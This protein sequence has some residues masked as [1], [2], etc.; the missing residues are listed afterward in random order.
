M[1]MSN[2]VSSKVKSS[3]Q[4]RRAESGQ[5]IVLMALV[6]II[7]LGMLGLAIDGGG[8]YFLWR[9]AQNASDAAVLAA[10][11][12]RC[13]NG[14]IVKAGLEAAFKNGFDNNGST[15]TVVVRNPP[16]N[17]AGVGN[18]NYVQVDITAKKPSFFIQ[19]VYRAPLQVTTRA[20]GFCIPPFD[21]TAVPAVFAGSTTCQN[22]IHWTNSTSS[23][24]GGLFSNS[25]ILF[26]GGGGGNVIYG[27]SGAVNGV[28][29]QPQNTDWYTGDT[30]PQSTTPTQNAQPRTDP[31][32]LQLA[33]Y[34][35]NA[36]VSKRAKLYSA[37]FSTADDPD[38]KN[39]TW[40]PDNNR[41]LEGLYYV[42]GDV[43]IGVG[44]NVNGDRNGD[45]KVEG[46]SI[47]AT[48]SISLNTGPGKDARYYIDGLLT[49]S[50]AGQ[51]RP[52]G[53]NAVDVSG[54]SADWRGVIY[55]PYGGV[56]MNMSTL[57]MVGTIIANTITMGG[58]NFTL[59][60]DPT[61]LPPRPPSI[62]VAE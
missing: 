12:A 24:T 29:Y 50:G 26:G 36:S 6:M 4:I 20:V 1:N 30:P 9:D 31:L 27:D 7:L 25:D 23:V 15:N 61:I 32:N 8:L 52:C 49:Y 42:D 11:Y 54:S 59:I 28:D 18:S 47:V 43:S 35:P 55:A 17:G 40:N 45:G 44:V 10:S 21:P 13:T 19:L 14:D 53:Y 34:A 22:A 57:N 56:N 41:V 62:Q 33:D 2:Q 51:G 37:I 46:I 3:V 16:T 39:G 60:Y 48:G 58:S 38:Y 5:A